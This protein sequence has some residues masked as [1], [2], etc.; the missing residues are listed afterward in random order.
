MKRVLVTGGRAPVALDLARNFA[1]AGA[2]VFVA[3]SAPCFLCRSSRSATKAFRVPPPR[4]APRAFADAIRAIVRREQID[5]IV[6]T[7]EEVFYLG[8]YALQLRSETD[9]FCADFALLRELH[10]KWRFTHLAR[11]LGIDVPD[12][13][14]LRSSRD[15][16]EVTLPPRQLVF[17]PVFSR[18]A[19]HTLVSPSVDAMAALAPTEERPWVA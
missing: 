8:R 2:E 13:W 6:P 14:L 15:L 1:A 18:F 19:V 10:D 12:T 11:D 5:L 17:K 16:D 9:L 7:C 4:E 3:D